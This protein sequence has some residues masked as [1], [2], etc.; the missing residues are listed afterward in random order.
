[1]SSKPQHQISRYLSAFVEKHDGRNNLMIVYYTGHGRYREDLKYLELTGSLKMHQKRGIQNDARANWNKAEEALHSEDI[2]G[3]VLTILDTCY[4]SNMQKSSKEDTRIFESMSACTFDMTTAAPGPNSFTRALIDSLVELHQIYKDRSFTTFHLNQ[5]IMSKPNRRDTPSILWDR[6]QQH[7]RHIRLAPLPKEEEQVGET[8]LRPLPRGYLTLRFAI[9]N[10][11]LNRE[12]IDYLTK[13][14]SSALHNKPSIGLQKI[15]WLGLKPARTVQIGRAA[16]AI[17][18]I[19]QW[20]RYVK[21]RRQQVSVDNVKLPVSMSFEQTV[22]AVSSPLRKRSWEGEDSLPKPKKGL[23][24]TPS[25]AD[26]PSPPNSESERMQG[27]NE[28][29]GS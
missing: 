2:E 18:V 29:E 22:S 23:L 21:R 6:R 24:A 4:S 13:T 17:R 15:D 12:Q 14:L 27:I 16:L 25:H 10:D 20:K 7:E 5:R 26:P 11:S 1:V 19:K 9:R 28:K 8:P 3:D